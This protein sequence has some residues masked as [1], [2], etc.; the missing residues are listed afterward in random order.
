MKNSLLQHYHPADRDKFGAYP[1]NRGIQ[2][3]DTLTKVDIM[4]AVGTSRFRIRDCV[5]GK[6]ENVV[7]HDVDNMVRH[8][9]SVSRK[10]DDK[11]TAAITAQFV[12]QND[13]CAV[14]VDKSETGES[15]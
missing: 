11:A 10:D 14:P 4:I 8:R 2:D 1:S 5:L 9:A 7:I 6:P 3:P 15:E 13:D 12:R